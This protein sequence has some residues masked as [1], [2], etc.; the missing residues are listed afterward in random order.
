VNQEVDLNDKHELFFAILRSL[1][2]RLDSILDKNNDEEILS[3]LRALSS[4][5]KAM[6]CRGIK[7]LD[8]ENVFNPLKSQLDKLSKSDNLEISFLAKYASQSLVYMGNDESLGMSIFRRGKLA[9]GIVTDIK[10]IEV[11][12]DV[13]KFESAYNKLIAMSDISI[14]LEWYQAL[15]FIDSLLAEQKFKSIELF[16]LHSRYNHN[17]TFMQGVCFRLEQIAMI[18]RDQEIG[19]GAMKL[20]QDIKSH[21]TDDVGRTA[22]ISLKRI[23]SSSI[24]KFN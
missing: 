23:L 8:R 6:L 15:M 1:K 7:G 21:Y 3:L 12:F 10:D 11:N 18:Y 9:I 19:I 2:A 4:L 22:E 16:I 24:G 14:K 17:I 5:F 13:S 20:L